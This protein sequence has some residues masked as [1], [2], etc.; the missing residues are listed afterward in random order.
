MDAQFWGVA[1]RR[2]RIFLVADF[3]GRSAPQTACLGIL[4][5][6]EARGKELPP[7]LRDALILQAGLAPSDSTDTTET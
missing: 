1:Q 4:R 6:A 7:Q 3:A 5:R 2:K